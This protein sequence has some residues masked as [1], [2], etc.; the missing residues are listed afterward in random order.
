M[1]DVRGSLGSWLLPSR[2]GDRL[3]RRL[4]TSIALRHGVWTRAVN[5]EPVRTEKRYR[6]FSIVITHVVKEEL[7]VARHDGVWLEILESENG[8]R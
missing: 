1:I 8:R 3:S 5:T 6:S 7:I 4:A 2:P